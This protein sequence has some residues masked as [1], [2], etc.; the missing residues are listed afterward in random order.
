[1]SASHAE[2]GDVWRL[3]GRLG[4]IVVV[5]RWPLGAD[6]PGL[7]VDSRYDEGHIKLV[8][9]LGD[10][11]E[12]EL[13]WPELRMEGSLVH[14]RQPPED[15]I[16]EALEDGDARIRELKEVV[17]AIRVLERDGRAGALE[18]MLS[19]SLILLDLIT[20]GRRATRRREYDASCRSLNDLLG[21]A[22]CDHLITDP[23]C[24]E[25][26]KRPKGA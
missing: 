5:Q 12:W 6:G 4:R 9:L 26:T 16:L 10:K 2:V 15:R 23:E 7:A 13:E 18:G 19:A 14:P 24:T 21:V 25:C 3:R 11:E 1:M 17:A 8:A 20:S 22:N